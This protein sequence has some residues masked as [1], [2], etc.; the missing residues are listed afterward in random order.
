MILLLCYT[1]SCLF[2]L[3]FL[4]YVFFIFACYFHHL[5]CFVLFALKTIFFWLF[6]CYRLNILW[7]LFR[8]LWTRCKESVY[9]NNILKESPLCLSFS[10]LS[11]RNLSAKLLIKLQ[12]INKWLFSILNSVWPSCLIH[13][14]FECVRVDWG[15]WMHAN[16]KH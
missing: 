11:S 12:Q 3:L 7:L 13:C 4:N 15:L 16:C 14:E 1:Q 8:R 6:L 2:D 10:F 9:I 5:F